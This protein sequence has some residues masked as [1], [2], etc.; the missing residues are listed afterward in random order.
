MMSEKK[1]ESR[2]T[3]VKLMNECIVA[4]FFWLTVYITNG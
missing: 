4:Q 2:P 1:T 3:F